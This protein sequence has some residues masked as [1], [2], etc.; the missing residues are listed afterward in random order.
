MALPATGKLGFG[1]MRL[2]K[3]GDKID[4]AQT[5][6][7]VD[8][9]LDAGF[10]YFDT[11]WAYPGSEEA[12]RKALVE[13]H[14]RDSFLLASKNAAWLGCKSADEATAQLDTSLARSGAGHFDFYL[15]HNL[16][17]A[18][19]RV[20]DDYGLCF[21]IASCPLPVFTAIGHERDHHIA[22]RVAFRAVKTPTALADEFIEAFAAEDERLL[23][24]GSQLRLAALSRLAA[25]EQRVRGLEE[26]IAASDPRNVLERGYS[27]VTDASGVVIKRAEGVSAGDEIEVL[28]RDGRLKC[29]V[30]T[31][32]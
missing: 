6:R 23:A 14:P 16:G 30:K 2:P 19:T 27:L 24:M 12:I 9:F 28:F 22:D 18:R 21:A 26:R 10:T 3:D 17:G 32:I 5:S 31:K 20:F 1:L 8:R 29:L 11:A 25:E 15:L 7:M 13:R 4:I